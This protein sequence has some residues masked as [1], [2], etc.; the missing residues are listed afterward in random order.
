MI[1]FKTKEKNLDDWLNN[2]DEIEEVVKE[3]LLRDEKEAKIIFTD[4]E[5]IVTFEEITSDW[6]MG[7]WLEFAQMEFGSGDGSSRI[8]ISTCDS[9]EAYEK[10]E[11]EYSVEELIGMLVDSGKM[12]WTVEMYKIVGWCDKYNEAIEQECGDFEIYYNELLTKEDIINFI[13]N[14]LKEVEKT[15][16]KK[17]DSIEN[18]FKSGPVLIAGPT[19]TEKGVK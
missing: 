10:I 12:Y 4:G 19:F 16:Y 11:D 6:S 5:E 8:Y 7:E 2:I 1:V 14:K 17:S 18:E 13:K 9:S 15:K 3:M